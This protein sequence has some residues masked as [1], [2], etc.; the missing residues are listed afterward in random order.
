MT[1]ASSQLE[2]CTTIPHR[3]TTV[4]CLV[5]PYKYLYR[6]KTYHT[7]LNY[8]YIAT[9]LMLAVAP[10]CRPFLIDFLI[11]AVAIWSTTRLATTSI[12]TYNS[13]RLCS[14]MYMFS[15]FFFKYALIFIIFFLCELLHIIIFLSPFL[16]C[17]K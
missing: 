11:H 16:T 9:Y 5:K 12:C 2:I 6:P 10:Y 13:R 14:Y 1:L 4:C 7:N 8:I 17:L 3:I 15:I